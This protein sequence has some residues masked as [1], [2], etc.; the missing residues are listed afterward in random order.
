MSN[1]SQPPEIPKQKTHPAPNTQ[2]PEQRQKP[3][4]PKVINTPLTLSNTLGFLL[5]K[6]MNLVATIDKKHSAPWLPLALLTF[7]SLTLF[8]VV[9]GAF[10]AGN[11]LWA[12]PLKIVGGVTFAAIICLPSLYIFACLSGIE[13]RFQTL[14]A[15]LLSAIAITALLLVGFA[16]VIWLFSTSSS[17][18]VFFG[19]LCLTLWI[20]CLSF[21]FRFIS[22]A[23]STLG[24]KNAAHLGVWTGVFLL[25]TIQMPTTL[26]PII[27]SSE[28]EPILTLDEKKF[29]LTHWAEQLSNN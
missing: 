18:A 3:E 25:V 23:A 6:P 2:S 7:L 20:I 14:A 4:T 22:R 29:F 10:S 13:A 17:S 16:P 28:H 15:I 26:R 24:T 27:D 21:G 1:E 8:G 12:A 11:Q 19:F 9:V 5:K